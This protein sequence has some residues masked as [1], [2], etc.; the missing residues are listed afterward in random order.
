[1]TTR[2]KPKILLVDDLPNNLVV[3]EELLEDM[4]AELLTAL[5]GNQALRLVAQHLPAL[6]LLDVQMPQMDGFEVA[7]LIRSVEQTKDIPIIF[8]T[9]AGRSEEM[10]FRGYECGAVDYIDKPIVEHVL[11]SKVNVFLKLY[12]QRKEIV[13][14]NEVLELRVD[15]RT[16]DLREALSVAETAMRAK[17]NFLASM[18]HELKTPMNSIIGFTAR[19]IKNQ[20]EGAPSRDIE[21]LHIV[22]RNA[23]QLLALINDLL[24]MAKID[25]GKLQ[26]EKVPTS[27]GQVLTDVVSMLEVQASLK[28]LDLQ[29]RGEESLPVQ[30]STDPTR[31]RQILINI[32]GNAIKF[33][34]TGDV[35]VTATLLDSG[36][37]SPMI[38]IAVTDTGIGMTED[39]LNGLF[40]PFVQ[41]N[42]S[43]TR[44]FGGTGLGLAISKQLAEMLGGRID[45]R[46]ISGEGSTFT[47]IVPTG[48]LAGVGLSD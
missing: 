45:V 18:S 38:S 26:V 27:P 15:E 2:S 12:T 33:S 43:T 1:M 32:I 37:E 3:L 9:A 22:E 19:M 42:A 31:L 40:Q 7:T 4:D 36:P 48:T 35:A 6:V 24:D 10:S 14:Q 8:V 5:S 34:S 11:K 29:L 13:W 28:G 25:E 44:K 39:E 21:A 30:I 47:L 23:K 16:A 20:N 46:S 17:A 41:A